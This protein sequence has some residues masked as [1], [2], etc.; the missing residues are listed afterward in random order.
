[1]EDS[2]LIQVQ[3][4]LRQDEARLFRR[5]IHNE[6]ASLQEEISRNLVEA[7]QDE[8]KL[9]PARQ[10]AQRVWDLRG[11]LELMEKVQAGDYP[12]ADTKIGI[13]EELLW[14]QT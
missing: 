10:S 13:S 14:R 4:W 6:I 2:K 5:L 8:R 7:S 9:A 12:F 11:M 1:M 3:S